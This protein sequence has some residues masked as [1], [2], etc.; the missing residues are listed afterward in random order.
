MAEIYDDF[1]TTAG[2]SLLS[3]TMPAGILDIAFGFNNDHAKTSIRQNV[4]HEYEDA[5][6]VMVNVKTS[7]V[8]ESLT[9]TH[10]YSSLSLRDGHQRQ[11]GQE[12]PNHKIDG[13]DRL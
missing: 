8:M 6:F 10:E 12:H 1:Y 9:D 4:E 5:E 2:G 3:I 7:G 13:P 11:G